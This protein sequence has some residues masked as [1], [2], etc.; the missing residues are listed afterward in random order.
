M[1]QATEHGP[2]ACLHRSNIHMIMHKHPPPP[3]CNDDP[4]VDRASLIARWWLTIYPEMT[5]LHSTDRCRPHSTLHTSTPLNIT[6]HCSPRQYIHKSSEHLA[7]RLLNKY[8][9]S[10]TR[11][12]RRSYRYSLTNQSLSTP[13]PIHASASLHTLD[14]H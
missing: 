1:H 14:Y 9:K 6:L 10:R 3:P 13:L 7:Q 12:S 5:T 11:Q 2:S 8:V 4:A